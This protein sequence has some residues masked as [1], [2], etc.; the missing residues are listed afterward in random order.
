MG[1]R[2]ER[3]IPSPQGTAAVLCQYDQ[4]HGNRGDLW[5]TMKTP[6]KGLRQISGCM[7]RVVL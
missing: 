3:F 6:S 4:A 2:S 5:K 7:I 1:G